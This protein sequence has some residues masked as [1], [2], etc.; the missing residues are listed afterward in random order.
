MKRDK[1][2]HIPHDAWT[3][4][5]G[6]TGQL[7]SEINFFLKAIKSF[8]KDLY[9]GCQSCDNREEPPAASETFGTSEHEG[10][11]IFLRLTLIDENSA[12]DWTPLFYQRLRQND[13]IKRELWWKRLLPSNVMRV[14]FRPRALD[15]VFCWFLPCYEVFSLG[16]PVFRSSFY[17]NQH[18]KFH[19]FNQ[20]G[21]P[22]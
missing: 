3:S 19:W 17:K 15:W 18:S 8:I 14:R 5:L 10:L 13:R 11:R 22:A 12:Q 9:A 1:R 4:Q 6:R 16:C 21:A 2:M 7:I 20:D